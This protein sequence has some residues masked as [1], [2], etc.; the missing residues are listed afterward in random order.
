MI[1][2]LPAVAIGLALGAAALVAA[3]ALV[4]EGERTPAERSA[5]LAARLR[6]PDC[7][8][9][10]V[11]DSPTASAVEI[12]R[13][14]DELLAG[15]ASDDEIRRHFVDRYGEWILLAPTA[16]FIWVLPYLVVL[17]GGAA[18]FGWLRSRA[19]AAVPPPTTAGLDPAERRRLRDEVE[20]I[21]A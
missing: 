21:D 9:L 14:I 15:G 13:Q 1:R 4:G 18:L 20:A 11:A 2:W 10:S 19:G 17:G 5:A 16:P 6:C 3:V 12:R 8:G 7:R